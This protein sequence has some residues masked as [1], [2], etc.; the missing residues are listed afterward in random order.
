MGFQC[1]MELTPDVVERL[2]AHSENGLSRTAEYRFV[3]TPE[4]LRTHDYSE[5][6]RALFGFLDKLAARYQA[7]KTA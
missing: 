6:N 5:M 2:I 3:N 4:E 7:S 1:H